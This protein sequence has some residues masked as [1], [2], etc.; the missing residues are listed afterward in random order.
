MQI[1]PRAY[2]H[3]VLAHWGDDIINSTFGTGA[4]LR[5]SPITGK[6]SDFH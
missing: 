1:N 5:F 4:I 2:P 6:R 3:P